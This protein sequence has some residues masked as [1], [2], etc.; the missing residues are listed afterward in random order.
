MKINL[1][2]DYL[3]V[4]SLSACANLDKAVSIYFRTF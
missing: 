3:G 2:L 4:M 1:L